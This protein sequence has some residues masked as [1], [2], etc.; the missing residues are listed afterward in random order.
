MQCSKDRPSLLLT[1]NAVHLRQCYD[2]SI[3]IFSWSSCPFTA[4]RG[5]WVLE[6]VT[7]FYF[8]KAN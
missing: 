7:N 1:T 4:V 3:E 6:P 5:D 2:S 8:V